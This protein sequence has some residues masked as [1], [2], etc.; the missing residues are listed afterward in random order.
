MTIQTAP[1]HHHIPIGS[2]AVALAGAVLAAATGYGAA[3]LVLDEA[4]APSITE[5]YVYDFEPNGDVEPGLFPGTNR[6]ERTLMHR[7]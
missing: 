2:A 1:H 3:T 6:E 5:P 4:P 7:R